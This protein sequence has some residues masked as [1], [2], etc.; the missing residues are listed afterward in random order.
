MDGRCTPGERTT[1]CLLMSYDLV[2]HTCL[3]LIIL[4][5]DNEWMLGA[6]L[7]KKW[8]NTGH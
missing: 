6:D 5:E 3:I 7:N 1:R 2:W 8:M 4:I